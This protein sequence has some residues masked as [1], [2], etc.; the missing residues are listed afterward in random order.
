MN[1]SETLDD[2]IETY[3]E[4]IASNIREVRAAQ[5]ACPHTRPGGSDAYQ[6]TR[7]GVWYGR[8][9]TANNLSLCGICGHE[10]FGRPLSG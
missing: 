7:L 9:C 8:M 10:A 1:R 5:A 2:V 6:I 4:L 3:C